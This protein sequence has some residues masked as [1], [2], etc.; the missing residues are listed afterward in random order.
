MYGWV[1]ITHLLVITEVMTRT[2]VTDVSCC[3][4]TIGYSLDLEWLHKHSLGLATS[5]CG[6]DCIPSGQSQQLTC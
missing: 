1:E 5:P 2:L 6:L 4:V 3:H